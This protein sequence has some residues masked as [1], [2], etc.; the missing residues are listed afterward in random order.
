MAD[1]TLCF[2]HNP[3]AKDAKRAAVTRGGASVYNRGLIPLE[4]VDFTDAKPILWLMADTIN[5]VRKVSPDG[6]MD[7]KTANCIGQLTRVMLE[8]QREISLVERLERLE[9]YMAGGS[10]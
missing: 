10:V 2:S 8:A 3:A 6:S 7:V 5:R 1:A 4:P 9:A